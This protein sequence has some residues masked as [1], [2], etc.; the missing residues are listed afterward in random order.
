[1]RSF[2]DFDY[3]NMAMIPLFLFSGVFFPLSQ[4]SDVLEII[5]RV[6]PLYQGVVLVRSLVLGDLHWSLIANAV[7][8][9][10]MGAIGLRVAIR[11]LGVLLQP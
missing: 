7:Y 10:A 11:R 3:V 8:L 1:M 4:Y 9:A 5:I 2:V 6:T